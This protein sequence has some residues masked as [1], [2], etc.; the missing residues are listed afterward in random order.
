MPL[1]KRKYNKK[2]KYN[3]K[4]HNK[5]RKLKGGGKR[6]PNDTSSSS[7]SAS[8]TQKTQKKQKPNNLSKLPDS[9]MYHIVSEYFLNPNNPD[10][11]S[12]HSLK[13]TSKVFNK[14]PDISKPLREKKTIDTKIQELR[15]ALEDEEGDKNATFE[16]LIDWNYKP[17]AWRL[18]LDPPGQLD[19]LERYPR[20]KIT[21][22]YSKK[23]R[24]PSKI[25]NQKKIE[26]L[27]KAILKAKKRAKELKEND[28]SNGSL[29][30]LHFSD[31]EDDNGDD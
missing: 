14:N 19:F 29:S 10:Y 22:N 9:L 18:F 16:F 28:D 4:K 30:S 3:T 26:L 11:Q 15:A 24:M 31:Y 12:L 6:K 7:S 20:G 17:E 13:Q 2:R 25:S 8:K 1:S 21:H 5:K 27:E 23:D